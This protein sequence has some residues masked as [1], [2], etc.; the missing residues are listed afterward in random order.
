[1]ILDL[2]LLRLVQKLILISSYSQM[3]KWDEVF[4]CFVWGEASFKS[5]HCKCCL[6]DYWD[7]SE[8]LHFESLKLSDEIIN[9]IQN[10]SVTRSFCH[11]I[12][13][14]VAFGTD[15]SL[16]ICPPPFKHDWMFKFNLYGSRL[17]SR[18]SYHCW[19]SKNLIV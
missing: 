15:F 18:G 16:L 19:E 11:T 14:A 3:I 8:I 9:W 7:C 5:R 13:W 2:N 17:P 12:P 10:Y 4:C 6:T 1:M